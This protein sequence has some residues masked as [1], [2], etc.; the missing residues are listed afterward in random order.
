VV[1]ERFFPQD[2]EERWRERRRDRVLT[3]VTWRVVAMLAF[4]VG[5]IARILSA[6]SPS[7]AAYVG[8]SW[9][10]FAT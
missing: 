10:A 8:I 7:R 4:G 6:D 9:L 5:V 2:G 1:L 3:L